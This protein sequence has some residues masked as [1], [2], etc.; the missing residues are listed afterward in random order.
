MKKH[1]RLAIKDTIFTHVQN[2]SKEYIIVTLIFI[3]GLFLGV[4]FINNISESQM[5]EVSSYLT[6][7]IEKLKNTENLKIGTM[8][9]TTILENTVLAIT[10][11]FF[12]TTVIRN[13]YSFW[14]CII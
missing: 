11:W 6:N 2:N 5:T 12:G 14:N 1:K 3:I 9:K 4:M 8:L 7:F 10:L 13:S